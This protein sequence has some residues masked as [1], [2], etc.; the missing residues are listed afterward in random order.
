[1]ASSKPASTPD[2]YQ[3]RDVYPNRAFTKAEQLRVATQIS[4]LLT[5]TASRIERTGKK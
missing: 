2:T 4:K 3:V 5:Q 1:M